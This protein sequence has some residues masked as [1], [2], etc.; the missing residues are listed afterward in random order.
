MEIMLFGQLADIAGSSSCNVEDVQDT[1]GL[2]TR[3]EGMFPG[4]EKI[5][6]MVAVNRVMVQE[7]IP[8]AGNETVALMP[9]FSG[10]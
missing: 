7:N 2:K 8:L 1:A 4:L 5:K 9:P 10:G 6:Y 3:L